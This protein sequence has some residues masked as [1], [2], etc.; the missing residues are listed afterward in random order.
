MLFTEVKGFTTVALVAAAGSAV[1]VAEAERESLEETADAV[2]SLSAEAVLRV[3]SAVEVSVESVAEEVSLGSVAAEVSVDES[4]V[5][6]SLGGG[7][8]AAFAT[9]AGG[10]TGTAVGG[11]T[12]VDIAV[13]AES[14]AVTDGSSRDESVAVGSSVGVGESVPSVADGS[15]SEDPSVAEAGEDESVADASKE[16]VDDGNAVALAAESVTI[17][18]GVALARLESVALTAGV[19][20]TSETAVSEPASSVV[21]SLTK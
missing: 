10:G 14:V 21:S 16:S 6:V 9:Q 13:T 8:L 2:V 19:A 11:T 20:D 3:G 5:D 7:K 15:T 12:G 1:P 4:A 18:P 17:A